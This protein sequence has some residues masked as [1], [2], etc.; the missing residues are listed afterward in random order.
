MNHL[1]GGFGY[2]CTHISRYLLFNLKGLRTPKE[3]W[4]NLEVLF[5]KQDE[6]LGHILENEL[7]A[8]RPKN[9]ETI[10][11]FFTR[12]RSLALQCRQCRIERK[13]K[14]NVLSI[15]RKLGSEYFVFVSIFHSKMDSFPNWKI[16]SL[17]SFSKSLIKEQEKLI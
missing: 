14:K 7:V 9:F 6:L 17:D 2:L 3:D 4:E 10:Q 16:P 11:Q 1:D 12:F 13:D 8:L 15:L 5:G